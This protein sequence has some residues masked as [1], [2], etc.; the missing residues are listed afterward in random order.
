VFIIVR[1]DEKMFSERIYCYAEQMADCF[2]LRMVCTC[3]MQNAVDV[4]LR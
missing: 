3:R 4:T 2:T 1:K